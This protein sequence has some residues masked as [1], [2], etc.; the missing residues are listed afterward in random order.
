L[1]RKIIFLVSILLFLLPFITQPPQGL[2]RE[3]YKA[4]SIFLV[5]LLWW[6][7]RFVPLMI[8]SLLGII[9]FP[10][11]GIMSTSSVYSKFGNTAVFFI[12]GSLII[13]S[14]MNRSGLSRRIALRF[15]KYFGKTPLSLILSLLY[16]A[17]FFSVFTSGHAVAAILM[18]IVLE[19]GSSLCEQ[20][21]SETYLKFLALAPMWGA[22]IGSNTSFLG[23][24]RA[25]LGIEM[26]KNFTGR[27]ISFSKWILSSFPVV[28]GLILISTIILIK[29]T[30]K[31][32]DIS[33]GLKILKIKNEELG[34]LTKREKYISLIITITI[35]AWI[36]FGTSLGI[37]NIA[38]ASVIILFVFNLTSWNE[39]EK[40]VNW[41]VVLMYGGAIVLGS[42][43][44]DTGVTN[45]LMSKLNISNPILFVIIIIFVSTLLTEF[46]SN[47][48]V[49][50]LILPV[51]LSTGITANI[52]PEL[53]V[54]SVVMSAG[55][56]FTMPM[57]TPAIAIMSSTNY[58]SMKDTFKFGVLLNLSAIA[59]TIL[60]YLLYWPLLY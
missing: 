36:F 9:A 57:S 22:I 37:A 11:L 30:P 3:A 19:I 21:N 4:L 5:S 18:P 45:W 40:D 25:P 53:L 17:A 7:T 2:S 20:E 55:S 24:A 14:A 39:V 32:I 33:K 38:I 26:L 16:L 52:K 48:A 51:V 43:L 42:A 28:T 8:T 47:T 54:L 56:A 59:M 27:E 50:A 31:T 29:L 49:V 12:L 23:G 6:A 34:K 41:G 1:K 15:L 10:L 46:M 58:I 35:F 13:A 60:V 44:A